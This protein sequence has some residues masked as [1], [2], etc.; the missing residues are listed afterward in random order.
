[1]LQQTR[2]SQGQPYYISFINRF[3]T[4]SDLAKANEE[5]ILLEWQGLGYYTRARNLHKCAKKIVTDYNG[6]FPDS[7]NELIKLPGIGP[8]TAAAIASICFREPVPV[9]DGNVFRVLSRLFNIEHDISTAEGKKA[10][11]DLAQALITDDN[12][13]DFNQALMEFGAL[14]CV[15][16]NPACDICILNL[17]CESYILKN[18]LERPVKANK[19]KKRDRFFNYLVLGNDKGLYM[20]QRV[21]NDI[22]KGLYDFQLIESDNKLSDM[23]LSLEGLGI[24]KGAEWQIHHIKEYKHVLTHQ[25]IH[26][27]F[28]FIELNINNIKLSAGRVE[29]SG[30]YD[31]DQIENLPKPVLIDNYLKEEIF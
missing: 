4:V 21:K 29:N 22:W 1:M 16:K 25:V 30:F 9:L 31:F 12:P 19:K 14:Q 11:L 28:Y 20:N 5:E 10:F 18:Q 6:V 3:P 13:G 27:T 8:Y 7:Y 24:T 17:N 26:A 2:V 15:P 23:I